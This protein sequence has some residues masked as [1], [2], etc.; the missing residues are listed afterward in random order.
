MNFEI[1]G[2]AQKLAPA[3]ELANWRGICREFGC[4]EEQIRELYVGAQESECT[5]D[6]VVLAG[7]DWTDDIT[8]CG[9]G[10]QN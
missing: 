9:A 5:L 8:A 4:S 10:L 3:E 7:D 1:E 2:G 6:T